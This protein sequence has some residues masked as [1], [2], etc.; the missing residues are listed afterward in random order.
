L[1][2]S[3]YNLPGDKVNVYKYDPDKKQYIL[4]ADNVTVSA[5]GMVTYINNTCSDYVITTKTIANAVKSDAI[6]KQVTTSTNNSSGNPIFLALI[7]IL[8]FAIGTGVSF[9]VNKI[10][11]K[12]R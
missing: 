11:S 4:I 9:G 12:R 6:A 7:G 1:V 5:G 3:L 8:I 10:I 2:I